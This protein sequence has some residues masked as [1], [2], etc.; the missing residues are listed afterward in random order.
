VKKLILSI[1]VVLASFNLFAQDSTIVTNKKSD[2]R[3]AKRQRI[4]AMIKQE[5]EGNLSF[6]KQTLFGIEA[7]TNGYGIFLEIGRRRSQRFTTTY[8]LELSE[9]KHP[10]EEKLNSAENLFNNSFIYGKINNFYQAKLGFGQQYIFG[11]KGNK[12]GVAIIALLNGGISAGLLKPYYLHIKDSTGLEKDVSY[13]TD[14]LSFI[15]PYSPLG[16]GGFGKGWN[17]LQFK[18]GVFLKGGLRFDFGRYNEKVQAVEI[19]MSVEYYFSKI[20]MM[21]YS[22]DKNLFFQGH[23]AFVFGTRK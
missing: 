11:Q 23:I 19:G 17:E 6:T 15:Y 12:N 14:S 3:E 22:P 13:Y 16:S 20:P 5:E 7:R 1:A 18:P 10:K 2:K 8:S 9:I 21:V 4:N